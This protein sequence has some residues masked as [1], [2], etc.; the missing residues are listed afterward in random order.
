MEFIYTI[1]AVLVGVG[2]Y[3]LGR[4]S[5]KVIT[6]TDVLKSNIRR[7]EKQVLQDGVMQLK[8]SIAASGAVI[9][10]K[11]DDGNIKVSLRVVA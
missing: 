4:R 6:L 7:S 1:I 11:L 5:V 3:I 10:E 8:D 9:Q 2:G